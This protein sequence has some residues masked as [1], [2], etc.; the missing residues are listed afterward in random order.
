MQI[1]SMFQKDI[2]RKI[3][4]VVKVGQ[5]DESNI[6]QELEE[7]VITRELRRHFATLYEA[8]S[9][10]LDHPTDRVGVWI[11][12]F[13]GSGKSHFLKMLSYLLANRVVEGTATIDYFENKFADDPM[14]AAQAR[15]CAEVPTEAILFNI[16]NKGPAK[17]DNTAVLRTFARVFYEHLGF[18]GEDLK[19]AR[20]E[21]FIEREHKTEAFRAAFERVNGSSWTE[22][23]ESYDFLEDDV[24]EAL[25]E[26][27]VMGADAASHWF[28]G[29]ET[30]ELSIDS[31]VADIQEYV[32]RRKA[33]TGDQRFRLLFMVDE[34]GQYI[35][36]D[37]N[38]MLNLQTLVE[39]LGARCTGSVWVMVTSQEAI[40]EVT[41]GIAGNDFSKIQGRFNTRLSL[42]S[43]SVDEVIQARVLSK[44]PEATQLLQDQYAV[45]SA[46]LKNLFTFENSVGDL[47]GYA[48]EQGF[49]ASFPFASYQ[50]RVFQNVLTEIRKH[51]SSGKHLSGGERSMLSGF[52]EAAQAVQGQDEN[53]LVPFW[54]FYDTLS[55]FLEGYIRRVV[56]RC[57]EAAAQGDQGLRPQD[58]SVLKLLFLLKHNKDI[59]ANL[60]NIAIL[61][62]D[63]MRVDMLAA[64]AEV[65]ASLERLERQNYIARSG[66]IYSFLTDEEQDVA[67]EINEVRIEPSHVTNAMAA[68]IY[69]DLYEARKLA[70]GSN[71]F[72]I[73]TYVDDQPHGSLQNGLTLRVVTAASALHDAG[74][75]SITLESTGNGGQAIVLLGG[76]DEYYRSLVAAL[77]IDR[78][79]KSKNVS[80]LPETTQDIIRCKQVERRGLEKEAKRLIDEALRSARFFV[81]GQE[82]A[83][84]SGNAKQRIDFALGY[85]IDDAYP[86]LSYVQRS[87]QTDGDVRAILLGGADSLDADPNQQAA[88]EVERYLK[89]QASLHMPVSML[90]LQ[91]EFQAKPF[92]WRPLDVAAV[93]ARLLRD[94]KAT[95]SYAGTVMNLQDAKLPGY[96][97]GKTGAEK[98]VVAIK[99]RVP[100]AT[101]RKAVALAKEFAEK[102]D[103]PSDEDGLVR[104][105]GDLLGETL[106][107]LQSLQANYARG[108]N[109]PGAPVVADGIALMNELLP[110]Y[111]TGDATAFLGAFVEHENDLLDLSEDLHDI[112]NFFP[113]QQRVFDDAQLL[114]ARME[115]EGDYLAGNDAVQERLARIKTILAEPRPYSHISELAPA[116]KAVNAAYDALLDERKRS[117]M[118]QIAAI[119]AG[120][121]AYAQG[122]EGTERAVSQAHEHVLTQRGAVQRAASLTDLDALSLRLEQLRGKLFEQV[123]HA[124]DAWEA[125]Q[126]RKRRETERAR[127]V[128]ERPVGENPVKVSVAPVAPP[129]APK[130]KDVV[131][132]ST[133]LVCLPER[134]ES[135]EE[136]D[137][138]VDRIRQTLKSR[139]RGHDAIRLI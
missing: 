11:S 21:Q 42:S 65:K 36:S 80:Q 97:A 138:Y 103:V 10:S 34:V 136:I 56:D 28:D 81:A 120:V 27:N 77:K 60:N 72:P 55:V 112:K 92:G 117:L 116:M 61:M 57:A 19:L 109:Y 70:R 46:V 124:H 83:S 24:I 9:E 108:K 113:A 38:L 63:D 1:R 85:L 125:E 122:K 118:D 75:Q 123:D 91:R 40:D 25:V 127:T 137:A 58:V 74:T 64:R 20:L 131:D 96:L 99:V 110:V 47:T 93:V 43:S 39:E 98:L 79:V 8:Y 26:A 94:Q 100:E 17:K 32:E 18:Y 12:G 130:P 3:N 84:N 114:V 49:V 86:R 41:G 44:T 50:F 52:Q 129:P 106:M 35:G 69:G 121:D 30:A 104:Y 2:N 33:E 107:E 59:E 6:R 45:Q 78:Y 102:Q 22:Q 134:L 4:G 90:E 31:L 76:T 16:D 67:R 101:L 133:S 14:V 132:L 7:Y 87:A 5:N 126:E 111:R 23:R 135:D 13:F 71:N 62:V 29:I 128:V 48:D 66:G 37:V 105:V 53:A 82:I 119:E 68:I 95:A 73:D 51:G 15:R 115:R 54:R 89:R 88:E 139:L